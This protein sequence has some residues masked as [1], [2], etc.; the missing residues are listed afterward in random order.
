VSTW[1]RLILSASAAAFCGLTGATSANHTEVGRL[2][3][4][5]Y[6][7]Q[8]IAAEL[9][10]S[11]ATVSRVL[12]RLGLNRLPALEPAEPVRRYERE[13]AGELIHVDINN[14]V[15][16][17]TAEGPGGRVQPGPSALRPSFAG[18]VEGRRQ[19][20]YQLRRGS[21]SRPPGCFSLIV[22]CG[23][24]PSASSRSGRTRLSLRPLAGLL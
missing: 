18:R 21:R 3:R 1:S 15:G 2:R 10:I 12:R 24:G 22:E 11:P 8:Q 19:V 13:H 5:R 20:G 6:T 14:H 17:P 16:L 7:G 23:R 9:R 4:Q